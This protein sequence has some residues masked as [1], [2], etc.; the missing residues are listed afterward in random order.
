MVEPILDER[1]VRQW[2]GQLLAPIRRTKEPSGE[3]QGGGEWIR[4]PT[5]DRGA[6]LQWLIE[7]GGDHDADNIARAVGRMLEQW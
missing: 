6:D 2:M 5:A 3:G 1:G 7:T 4:L